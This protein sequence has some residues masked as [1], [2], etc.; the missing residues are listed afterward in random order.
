MQINCYF[1]NIKMYRKYMWYN[2]KCSQ[3]ISSWIEISIFC[4]IKYTAIIATIE[5]D[6][7]QMWIYLY[8]MWSLLSNSR[9]PTSI[10]SPVY[11]VQALTK[12]IVFPWEIGNWKKGEN[13]GV[14]GCCKRQIDH[15][16]W[17]SPIL[18]LFAIEDYP[19]S[20]CLIVT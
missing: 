12:T 8:L 9:G 18:L 2:V 14:I 1:Q 7:S 20:T 6:C 4:A 15:A 13:I 10:C 17:F 3:T 16:I 19:T 11:F 5:R